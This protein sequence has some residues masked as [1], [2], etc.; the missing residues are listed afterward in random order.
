MVM[1]I[2]SY[3]R[4]KEGRYRKLKKRITGLIIIAV[5]II[6]AFGIIGVLAGNS[7]EYQERVS[8]LQE[9]HQLREE[10]EELKAQIE[11]LQ[12]QVDEKDAYIASIPEPEPEQE[13][14]TEENTEESNDEEQAEDDNPA[15]PREW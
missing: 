1:A 3:G 11:A 15:S 14:E 7:A 8:I 6:V 13:Q 9:N 5:I 12:G 4:I 10:N 2:Q